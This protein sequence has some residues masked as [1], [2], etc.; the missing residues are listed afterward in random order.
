MSEEQLLWEALESRLPAAELSLSLAFAMCHI[1]APADID[2]MDNV[3]L[4]ALLRNCR[5]ALVILSC[6]C[7]LRMRR[8]LT[9][10]DEKDAVFEQLL[11]RPSALPSTQSQRNQASKEKR[12]MRRGTLLLAQLLMDHAALGDA[13]LLTAYLARPFFPWSIVADKLSERVLLTAN[14]INWVHLKR[15]EPDKPTDEWIALLRPPA[16]L[17]IPS[18]VDASTALGTIS[19]RQDV[20]PTMPDITTAQ[21]AADETRSVTELPRRSSRVV[22]PPERLVDVSVIRKREH[23]RSQKNKSK[24]LKLHRGAAEA[25]TS[26]AESD[27][28]DEQSVD[29]A[30]EGDIPH[31]A[32]V[33]LDRFKSAHPDPE[34]VSMM[35]QLLDKVISLVQDQ[36]PSSPPLTSQKVVG[37][38]SEQQQPHHA[39]T[40]LSAE[41]LLR[42][43][44][45]DAF[46]HIG[47]ELSDSV[48]ES[49]AVCAVLLFLNL[50][51]VRLG[52]PSSIWFFAV[53]PELSALR[54]SFNQIPDAAL[55][56]TPLHIAENHWAMAVYSRE[57]NTFFGLDSLTSSP[58]ALKKSHVNELAKMLGAPAGWKLHRIKVTQQIDGVSCGYFML[59]SSIYIAASSLTWRDTISSVAFP[60]ATP[61]QVKE[62]VQ[63]LHRDGAWRREQTIQTISDELERLAALKWVSMTAAE[64]DTWTALK[65]QTSAPAIVMPTASATAGGE[66]NPS[67]S[68]EVD[69]TVVRHTVEIEQ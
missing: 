34:R 58:S 8:R 19:A 24:K 64:F 53:Y 23:R 46:D 43:Q 25:T 13:S 27:S 56:A 57:E 51:L 54:S 4:V 63:R 7:A 59:R 44:V 6:W 45:S 66:V 28:E 18:A 16:S 10:A 3:A 69:H 47:A 5:Q 50:C 21:P 35:E 37:T 9:G 30:L 68:P 65:R 14:V 29:T 33:L 2:E 38:V 20:P 42:Q 67:A 41:E 31:V 39:G 36:P 26:E 61:A 52:R 1:T 60:D 15:H 48:L 62:V 12:R 22:P 40:E 32:H 49:P 11:S 55:I 17:V